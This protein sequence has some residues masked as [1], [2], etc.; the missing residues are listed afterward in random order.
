MSCLVF[1]MIQKRNTS[2]EFLEDVVFINVSCLCLTTGWESLGS[3]PEDLLVLTIIWLY[4]DISS[5]ISKKSSKSKPTK[6]VNVCCGMK[7]HMLLEGIL[8]EWYRKLQS[9]QSQFI[10]N[11]LIH[12]NAGPPMVSVLLYH[13]CRLKVFM[14]WRTWKPRKNEYSCNRVKSDSLIKIVSYQESLLQK[15]YILD[16]FWILRSSSVLLKLHIQEMVLGNNS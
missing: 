4:R 2:M 8:R 7:C 10:H 9:E 5:V 3:L 14:S 16:G 6:S 12:F 11:C 13:Y 1:T 15:R